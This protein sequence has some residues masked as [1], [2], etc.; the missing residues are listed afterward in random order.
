MQKEKIMYFVPSMEQVAHQMAKNDPSIILGGRQWKFFPD[1][2]PDFFLSQKQDEIQGRHVIFLAAMESPVDVFP[3]LAFAYALP[4]FGALSFRMFLNHFPT[5]QNERLDPNYY[6]EPQQK[7]ATAKSMARMLSAI[8]LS[9]LGPARITM[10]DIHSLPEQFYFGDF[11]LPEPRSAMPII[12]KIIEPDMAVVFPDE[13]ADKRFS[14][15]FEGYYRIFC[16]KVR[17][18]DDDRIVRIEKGDPSGRHCLLVD[19][20]VQTGGTLIR[21]IEKLIERG[22]RKISV[23][24]TNA[25][26]PNDSWKK[27][28]NIGLVNFWFSD[29][30]P[31]MAAKLNNVGPF[32]CLSLAPSMNEVVAN[33][34]LYNI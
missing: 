32:K 22:A 13:G 29:S 25:V 8:P 23:F 19:D 12:R 3:Q 33:D 4:R 6:G 1:E 9:H 2:W 14:H 18:Q 5:G 11:V 34:R 7:I 10:F 15:M 24:V 16:S 30:R 26:F 31:T 27:F 28:L 20:V 21:N 17:T